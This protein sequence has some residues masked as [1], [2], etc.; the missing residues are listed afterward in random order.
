M[1]KEKILGTT[2]SNGSVLV[3]KAEVIS[4]L[5]EDD[6]YKKYIK[7]HIKAYIINAFCSSCGSILPHSYETVEKLKLALGW[8]HVPYRKDREYLFSDG[9]ASPY[10][11]RKGEVT[12]VEIRKFK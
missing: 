12:S 1:D 5:S 4:D 9:C 2:S 11:A 10:C 7:E 8:G 3:P 6:A